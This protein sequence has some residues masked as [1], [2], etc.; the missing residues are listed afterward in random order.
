M[1]IEL[2]AKIKPINNGTFK[3]VDA[4][5]VEMADG[6]DLETYLRNLPTSGE[7]FLTEEEREL[8]NQ[9]PNK[10]DD[11]VLEV[12]TVTKR[13]ILKFFSDGVELKQI[14][15][16]CMVEVE[17]RFVSIEEQLLEHARKLEELLY[18][19]VSANISLSKSTAE[20]GEVVSGLVVTWSYNKDIVSQKFNDVEIDIAD[21]TYTETE[22]ITS[23]TTY[24]VE[25]ND[26]KRNV[27]KS[28]TIKF[29][30]GKYYGVAEEGVYD[31]DFIKS[32]T[33]VLTENKNGN[34]TV[35][36][37]ENEF[38]Y[39]CIPTRFGTPRFSVG[40]FEGGFF[41]VDTIEFTNN[42]GYSENYDIYRSD[43]SSLGNTTVNVG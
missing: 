33:K 14:E 17:E 29:L 1:A 21:R 16:S 35:N 11:V 42:F 13:N 39:F 28:A 3:M 4:C 27:V 19:P 12:D 37:G 18:V 26:G 7:S 20:L 31:N 43:N 2:I 10:Y 30:N 8:L 41:K 25:G 38:I 40:G 15:I 9:I 32:L 24:K 34:F 36:C 5:D 23:D 22:D 6:Q